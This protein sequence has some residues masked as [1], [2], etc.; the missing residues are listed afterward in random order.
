MELRKV[1]GEYKQNRL[2]ETQSSQEAKRCLEVDDLGTPLYVHPNSHVNCC[3]S[4][5]N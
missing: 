2:H 1:K 5:D 3:S 4:H